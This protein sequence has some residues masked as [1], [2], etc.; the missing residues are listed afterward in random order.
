M[1]VP[2]FAAAMLSA[3]S[4]TAFASAISEIRTPAQAIQKT[5]S[6]AAKTSEF[7]K[8]QTMSTAKLIDRWTPFIKEASRRFGVAETWIK[9]VMRMKSGGR[10]LLADSQPIKSNAGAMG[11]MQIMPDTYKDMR[12]QYGLGADPYDPRDNVLAGAAYLRW[13]HEKYGYPKMFA[14]YN[15]G[16]GTLEAQVAGARE[17]PSETRAYVSGI[18]PARR[19]INSVRI[20]RASNREFAPRNPWIRSQH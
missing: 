20:R 19:R 4:N 2:V 10:T 15:A 12:E 7:A 8:E 17:L 14:A 3:S 1:Y 6:I 18:A 9:A 5:V 16:P 13:L 11:I